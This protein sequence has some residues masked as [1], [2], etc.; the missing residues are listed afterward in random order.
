MSL[1]KRIH[2]KLINRFHPLEM[3]IINES[4]K[5]A[6]HLSSPGSGESHFRVVIISQVFRGISRIARHRMVLDLLADELK[7]GVHALSLETYAPDEEIRC[8]HINN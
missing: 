6:G 3:E 5:H 1:Q 4:H 2:E 7:E 8:A